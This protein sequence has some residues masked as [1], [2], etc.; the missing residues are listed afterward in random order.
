MPRLSIILILLVSLLGGDCR[1]RAEEQAERR[2]ILFGASWCA[3]CLIEIRGLPQ[4]A[5]AAAPDRLIVAWTDSGA[6]RYLAAAPAN[7][8][9]MAQGASRRMLASLAGDVAGLPFAVMLDR[10]G[11]RCAEWR[12]PLTPRDVARLRALC[13]NAR[14]E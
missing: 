14:K 3:P 5:A 4:L 12:A 10:Q 9:P 1:A 11:R 6:D 8:E 7:V 13:R 2:I